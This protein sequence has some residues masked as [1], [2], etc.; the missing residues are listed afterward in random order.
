MDSLVSPRDPALQAAEV[1]A[2]EFLPRHGYRQLEPSAPPEVQLQ[3]QGYVHVSGQLEAGAADAKGPRVLDF[4]I[5]NRDPP[6]KDVAAARAALAGPGAGADPGSRETYLLTAG[7]KPPPLRDPQ[8]QKVR[9]CRLSTF[10]LNPLKHVSCHAREVVHPSRSGLLEDSL[11]S[12]ADLPC[13]KASDP[14]AVWLR[15]SPGQA[16]R[17]EEPSDGGGVEFYYRLVT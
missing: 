8:A 16:V 5:F 6:A 17:Y 10:L 13:V 1:V 9:I 2:S 14:V 11:A 15:A 12:R 4:L 7:E 3:T